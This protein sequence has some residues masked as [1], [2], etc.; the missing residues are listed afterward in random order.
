M[1]EINRL[2]GTVLDYNDFDFGPPTPVSVSGQT[3]NTKVLLTP[4][5]TALLYGQREI[6]YKRLDLGVILASPEGLVI[7]DSNTLLSEI[8]PQINS[9]FGIGMREEDYV[10]KTLPL[11]DPMDS[12]IVPRVLVEAKSTS[13]LFIGQHSLA[14]GP[15]VPDA[16]PLDPALRYF[17]EMT[18]YTQVDYMKM[19]TCFDPHGVVDTGFQFLRNCPTVATV[20]ILRSFLRNDGKLVLNGHFVL[21]RQN[22]DDVSPVPFD[23]QS[24]TVGLDGALIGTSA[25]FLFNANHA[26][27][28]SGSLAVEHRYCVDLT[29]TSRSNRLYR[30]DQSGV[31]D[32]AYDAEIGYVP[33]TINLCSNG[34]LYTTSPV[35]TGDVGG[36]PTQHVRIDRLLSDGSI[37]LDFTPIIITGHGSDIPTTVVQIAPLAGN[38]FWCLF[39]PL[40]GT[41][42]T[43]A[44][45]IINGVS[46][47]PTGITAAMAWNPIARFAESGTLVTTFKSVL[48][49][50]VASSIYVHAGSGMTSGHR[51]MVVTSSTAGFLSYKD[52]PITGFRHRQPLM[53]DT[54][55]NIRLLGGAAYYDQYKWTEAFNVITQPDGKFVSYGKMAVKNLLGGWDTPNNAVGKYK[56]DGSIDGII[57][58]KPLTDTLSNPIAIAAVHMFQIPSEL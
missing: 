37:D 11:Y 18:G 25:T 23:V 40:F 48:K 36:I 19:L 41:D 21:S 26:I 5:T 9:V 50:N 46:L 14:L 4:K 20:Q 30:Y 3:Y 15:V 44:S 28:Y 31:L 13:Y 8:I 24:I 47:V 22:E 52:N 57:F 51:P 2:N 55:A 33:A 56:A 27:K 16:S 39:L 34:N 6:F 10:E 42:I 35:Q 49:D 7:P 38:G 29:I 1:D 32:T 17:V 45:P 54:L 58:R 43:A 53:F 12:G